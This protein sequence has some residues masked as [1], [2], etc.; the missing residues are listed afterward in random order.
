MTIKSKQLILAIKAVSALFLMGSAHAQI[1]VEGP[2]ARATVAQQQST[3]AFM[4]LSS[5]VDSALVQADSPIAQ[6]V[7][8]HEMAMENNV[9]K[10]RQVPKIDLPAGQA[11]ELKPGSYHIMLIDL[12]RQVF[13]GTEVPLT[14]T[15]E[16]KDGTRK[17]IEVGAPVHA[18]TANPN[19]GEHHHHHKH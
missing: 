14:L 18:L 6:H 12:K 16:N 9:M 4:T 15:F 19:D 3:G 1:K 5:E 8:I 17:V 11:V 10:M 7:E 13:E 2:W